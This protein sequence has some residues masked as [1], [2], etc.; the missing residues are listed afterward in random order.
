MVRISL[1]RDGKDEES[2]YDW[3]FDKSKL[4]DTWPACSG[5]VAA[6][7]ALRN[8]DNLALPLYVK[9]Q[10]VQGGNV[11]REFS[12]FGERVSK[13]LHSLEVLIDRQVYLAS[14]DG[15]QTAQTLDRRKGISGFDILD[16]ITPL[17]PITTRTA[18]F[19]AWG[20][21]WI[22]LLPAIGAVTVFGK[23]FGE[24]IRPEHPDA[25][26]TEWRSIPKDSDYLTSS[27]ST[28]KMLYEVQL[29]R[30][31]PDLKVG[32]MTK[33]ISWT[34]PRRPLDMCKC[35]ANNS[36]GQHEHCDPVQFLVSKSSIRTLGLRNSNPVDLAV[37]EATGAVVFANLSL[38]GQRMLVKSPRRGDQAAVHTVASTS[39]SASPSNSG[40]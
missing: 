21:G 19:D 11:V 22:D 12:T 31:V 27:L 8:W 9:S 2:T 23:G 10:S 4:E 32:E 1:H 36:V 7:Q 34:S 15:I 18:R 30:R 38:F 17:G 28:L 40:V 24:L 33:R 39:T 20:D 13:I 16:L 35:I 37:L 3:V 14:Q 6:K 25:V 5:R 29:R 26:C